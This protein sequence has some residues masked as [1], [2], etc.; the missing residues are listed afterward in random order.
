MLHSLRGPN[1]P[2]P[3]RLKNATAGANTVEVGF[4]A[5]LAGKVTGKWGRTTTR[6]LEIQDSAV[7]NPADM[8]L[9]SMY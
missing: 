8:S 7:S 1:D 9:D 5:G 3:Q 4:D 2:A 6:T